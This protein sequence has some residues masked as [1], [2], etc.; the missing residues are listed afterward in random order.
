MSNVRTLFAY[1]VL[2]TVILQIPVV[3]LEPFVIRV[4]DKANK[5]PV[6]LVQLRTTNNVTFVTDNAGLIAFDLPEMMSVETWF[7]IEGHGYSVAADGFGFRGIRLTPTPGGEVTIEVDRRLPGKRLGRITG[8]G[9]YGESQ[10]L[11]KELDWRDQGVLGC[12]SVQN[13]L[14][15][16]QLFWLWGDTKLANYP[17]GRFQMT[18]ATTG[19]QPLKSFEPPLRLAYEHFRNEAAEVRDVASIPGP[20]PTWLNGL[21]SLPDRT[22]KQRMVATYSKIKPPMEVY[23]LGLCEWN[24]ATQIFETVYKLWT[25]SETSPNPPPAPHGHTTLWRDEQG[26]QW[27]L[28]GDPFPTLK[29]PATYEDWRDPQQWTE[30]SAQTMV[31]V[32]NGANSIQPHRG[33]IAWNAY[34]QKWVII[35]TQLGGQSSYLGEM[36]YAEAES[37]FGPWGDARQVVSHTDY[38]FYNPRMHPELTGPES[39]VL[40]FEATYT[41]EFSSNSQA[42]PKYDYNQILYRLDLDE[43]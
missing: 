17:L 35:F 12:D 20:G 1:C 29:C 4:I 18:G 3:A 24:D 5:W 14:H 23:E 37:P 10:K 31:S 36:W 26:G 21:C 33:S 30:V 16:G 42:T 9:L 34:R 19:L 39:A 11:G 38:T 8:S 25:R 41:R 7:S 13:V 15:N 28:F 27:V 43:L 22:G 32:S 2:A 40:L 6:P